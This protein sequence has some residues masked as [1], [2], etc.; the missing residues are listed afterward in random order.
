MR[1][2]K[3]TKEIKLMLSE[4]LE[5]TYIRKKNSKKGKAQG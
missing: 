1:E 4:N 3:N 2:S 5:N